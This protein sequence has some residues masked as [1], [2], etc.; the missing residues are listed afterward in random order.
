M[1]P[2]C[3]AIV[4]M[5]LLATTAAAAAERGRAPASVIGEVEI[6]GYDG[7][8]DDLLTAGL[9]RAGLQGATPATS[10]P[11]TAAELRRLAIYLN[12]R[13]LVDVAPGGGYGTLYGPG[14]GGGPEKIAGTEYLALARSGRQVITVAVQVPAG[15]DRRRPCIV[16]A[17]SS[18]SRGVYGQS[19][20]FPR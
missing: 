9:G 6:T 2:G 4:A 17:P 11:P 7:N 3:P 5:L 12:Y 16:T 15:F 19:C 1:R 20:A 8:K 13:A 18:G 10:S 14:V